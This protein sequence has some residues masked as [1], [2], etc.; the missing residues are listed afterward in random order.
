MEQLIIDSH[1]H[2]WDE[3]KGSIQGQV[4]R[5]QGGGKA[6]FKG[7]VRQMMP[8][9]MLDGKNTAELLLSN[10]DY[11]RVAGAVVTQEYIDGNQN[12]YLLKV[13]AKYPNRLKICG[14]LELRNEE[15][16]Q[17]AKNML[18]EEF[19]GIK[20]PAQWLIDKE[21]R[22]WLNTPELMAF[23]KAME[24]RNLFLS[25]DLAEGSAQVSELEEVIQECPNLR[26]AIGHFGMANRPDWKSQI[27]LGRYK[28]V[29]IES[30]GITW[31]FHEEFY[32]YKGAIRAIQ[33][34]I[35]LIGIDKVLWGSDYPRTMTAI[36]YKMA[37]DFVCKTAVLSEKEKSKFLGENAKSFYKFNTL[38]PM[39]FIRNM[40]ED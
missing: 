12:E 40:V 31:L 6:S 29:V 17:E 10:M 19:D 20:L 1:L 37:Y 32:P 15:S 16:M 36:T 3:L 23:F 11:A 26:V 27:L 39:Q 9:Y 22:I 13:K 35:D 25:I 33:E 34:A 28:N 30:G 8:P 4:V 21:H 14:L 7:E 2:L 24:R 38:P 5:S 18:D